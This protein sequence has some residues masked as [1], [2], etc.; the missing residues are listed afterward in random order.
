M[1]F[2]IWNYQRGVIYIRKF[3]RTNYRI[4]VPEVRLVGPKGEQFGVVTTKDAQLKADQSELDLVEVAPQSKPPV[5]RI[6]DFA[7]YKYDQEK[8]ERQAKKH[9]HKVHVKEIRLKPTIDENDYQVKLRKLI[10]FLGRGDKVKVRL[11]FRGREMAHQELG[12][13][14]IDRVVADTIQHGQVERPP[15]LEGRIIYMVLNKKQ[16]S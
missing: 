16:E 10:G 2:V 6:M 12:R 7:K 9:Q 8:K 4:R 1:G 5:C 13:R 14:V 11:M 3:I 15:K